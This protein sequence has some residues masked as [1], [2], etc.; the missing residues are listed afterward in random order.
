MAYF[1]T[2]EYSVY[3][4]KPIRPFN[5]NVLALCVSNLESADLLLFWFDAL[6]DRKAISLFL[7]KSSRL[8]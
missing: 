2:K 8:V 4:L 5:K 7:S 1:L 3:D 6:T